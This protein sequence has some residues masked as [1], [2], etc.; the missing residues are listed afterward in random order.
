MVASRFPFTPL[1]LLGDFN[2]PNLNWNTDP[3]S[4]SPF[5]AQA[6][7]FVD[8]CS[9]FGL[10][11]LVTQP[12]RITSTTSSTL[13]L[14]LTNSP[15]LASEITYM[16]G[17]SDHSMLAFHLKM[18]PPKRTKVKKLIVDYSNANFDAINDELSNFVASFFIQFSDRSVQSNWD[19]FAAKV[20]ELTKKYI[21]NRTIISN[22]QAPWYNT[23]IKRLSNRKKRL[24]RSAKL[25][26]S[27]DRWAI[28]KAAHNAYLTALKSSK[29]H[30]LSRTL[31]DMLANNVRK[32]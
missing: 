22:H 23:Y 25:A 19:I 17:I 29:L 6:K 13:D 11:Q 1:F 2:L 7:D 27:E 8:M 32:F 24:Y 5:S 14:I 9:V 30:F 3:P 15:D 26:P 4:L 12:T 28:Y 31:P 20:D 18:P 16:P 10:C 21:P